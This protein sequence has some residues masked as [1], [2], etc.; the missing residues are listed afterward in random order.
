[1]TTIALKAVFNLDL[2]ERKKPAI[3]V[4][5]DAYD[6]LYSRPKGRVRFSRFFK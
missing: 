6:A 1:M 2:R 3:Q 5:D 4:A